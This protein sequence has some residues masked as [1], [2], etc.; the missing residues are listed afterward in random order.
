MDA[1]DPA[2]CPAWSIDWQRGFHLTLAHVRAGGALPV[3]AGEVI[4]QGEDLG[5]W[6]RA[7]R[8]GWDRL[9]PVQH[10]LLNSVLGLEPAN[11]AELQP[12]RR[13]QADR[14][15]VNLAAARQFHAREGHL[16]VP[17]KHV[18]M[19]ATGEDDGLEEAVKL[20][21]FLDNTRRRAS[22][23]AEQRRADLD[24][25]GMRW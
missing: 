3:Q 19:I 22:K 24:A 17:R 16:V 12:T 2:W 4:V 5:A 21:A 23:L 6:T 15:A 20:G 1:I 9:T 7:Q 13:T 11:E 18:E 25:L 10:W 14:W 8:T